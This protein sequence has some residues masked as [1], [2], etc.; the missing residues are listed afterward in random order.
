M[1]T[2]AFD[3]D[4]LAGLLARAA[5]TEIMPRFRRLIEGEIRRKTSAA[6]VVTDADE[7]AE[8]LIAAELRGRYPGALVLGEEACSAEPALLEGLAGA[9]I[10]FVIDPVDGT[11]NFASGVPLFGVMLAVVRNG[12]TV[13]GI[14]HDPVGGDWV[15]G[16]RGAG[17]RILAADGSERTIRVADPVPVSEMTGALS[18]QGLAQPQRSIMARN[19]SRY[20]SQVGYRCAAH[21]YRLVASGYA[22][23]ALYNK[24]MPWDHLAGVLIHEEAGGHAA[25]FDGSPYRP[26]HLDGGILVAPDQ[27][28]WAALREALWAED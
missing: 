26:G 28:S 1:T 8:R 24:L 5:T 13:A 21:E 20:L 9:D 15:I 19:Q 18:L 23:F 3:I 2:H 11:F 14:I 22:H 12:E 25:R 17:A 4:W 6:D 27:E 10:A 7:Q 16:E